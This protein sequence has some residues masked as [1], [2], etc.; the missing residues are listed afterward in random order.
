MVCKGH[1]AASREPRSNSTAS[2]LFWKAPYFTD[3]ERFYAK[4]AGVKES[5]RRHSF[6]ARCT[7]PAAI[8]YVITLILILSEL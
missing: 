4:R 7:Q 1:S 8:C 6:G 5:N 3:K 2:F